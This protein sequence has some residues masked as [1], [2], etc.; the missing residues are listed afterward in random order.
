MIL[1][2]IVV[3]ELT[4][5]DYISEIHSR[6][7]QLLKKIPGC[8]SFNLNTTKS[9]KSTFACFQMDFDNSITLNIYLEHIEHQ[10]I[11]N[12][13]ITPNLVNG[14][15]SVAVL[16]YFERSNT[17]DG[18]RHKFIKYIFLNASR[19][20]S[21]LIE[22]LAVFPD[23]T[24]ALFVKN[25]SQEDVAKAYPVVLKLYLEG[26][27]DLNSDVALVASFIYKNTVKQ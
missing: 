23:K 16:D 12:E 9:N 1:R 6:L 24:N 3:L 13:L 5:A 2:H 25:N 14:I 8:L 21:D 4:N 17:V 10:F 20:V 18:T 22:L 26:E 11:V 15:S 7:N 27:L 19:D